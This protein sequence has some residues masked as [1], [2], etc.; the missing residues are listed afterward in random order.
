M[1]SCASGL[2]YRVMAAD[3]SGLPWLL[4][5]EISDMAQEPDERSDL[6]EVLG[7]TYADQHVACASSPPT[8]QADPRIFGPRAAEIV[9]AILERAPQHHSRLGSAARFSRG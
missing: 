1:A 4:V 5:R 2:P 7:M 8:K 6:D 9:L 3:C